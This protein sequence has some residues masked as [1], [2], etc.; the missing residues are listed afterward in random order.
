MV[1][2]DPISDNESSPNEGI[3]GNLEEEEENHSHNQPSKNVGSHHPESAGRPFATAS[4]KEEEET[5]QNDFW[6]TLGQDQ[7]EINEE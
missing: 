5:A 3:R 7:G 6:D 1:E 4:R 2:S